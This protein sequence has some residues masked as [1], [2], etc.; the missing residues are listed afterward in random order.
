MWSD[1]D[2]MD[3]YQGFTIGQSW[4][5]IKT[6]TDQIHKDN[7]YFVP[8]VDAGIAFK[9]KAFTDGKKDNFIKSPVGD[10]VYFG[11]VWPGKSAFPDFTNQQT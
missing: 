8:I 11:K 5:N 3:K 1:I 6:F 2:Y 4:S 9:S 7:W 10:D